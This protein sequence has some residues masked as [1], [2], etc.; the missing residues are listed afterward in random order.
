[1]PLLAVA[2]LSSKKKM[3]VYYF[4]VDYKNGRKIFNIF[5]VTF[6]YIYLFLD[7]KSQNNGSKKNAF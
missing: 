6:P 3:E 2:H 5:F 1:M 4:K 7:M